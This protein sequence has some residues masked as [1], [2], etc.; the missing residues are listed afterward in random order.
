MSHMRRI[1]E[2][3]SHRGIKRFQMTLYRRGGLYKRETA[4]PDSARSLPL[5]FCCYCCYSR[6]WWAAVGSFLAVCGR[7]TVRAATR[8]FPPPAEI[9]AKTRRRGE[10]S[11]DSESPAAAAFF[12]RGA[13]APVAARTHTPSEYRYGHWRQPK[14]APSQTRYRAPRALPSGGIITPA[15]T[16]VSAPAAIDKSR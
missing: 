7:Q 3:I 9:G 16:P 11:L 15:A 5:C 10:P 14:G 4:P 13:A 6:Y 8:R 12:R 2:G 1:E